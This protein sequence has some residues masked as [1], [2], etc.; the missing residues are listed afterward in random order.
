MIPEA[1]LAVDAILILVESIARGMVV[2]PGVIDRR[3]RAELP[4]LVTEDILMAGVRAGGDRQELHERIRTHARQAAARVKA[5]GG[6]NPLL[7]LLAADPVFAAVRDELPKLLDPARYI[8]RS[9]EQ[10]DSF[11]EREV[12]PRLAEARLDHGEEPRV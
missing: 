11:L 1:F 12:E 10:V 5:E 4:F 6:D 9:R 8:G 7:D 3:L 2:H